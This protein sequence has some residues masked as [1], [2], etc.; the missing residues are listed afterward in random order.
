MLGSETYRRQSEW[1]LKGHYLRVLAKITLPM[2][3]GVLA[4]LLLD[5]ID[6]LLVSQIGTVVMTA[7]GLS[8]PLT[9]L[10]FGVIVGFSIGLVCIL[11]KLISS[12]QCE[13]VK[14][15]IL[16]VLVASLC[17]GVA[18]T[19]FGLVTVDT[20]LDLLGMKFHASELGEWGG[21]RSQAQEYMQLRYIGFCSWMLA[22]MC[23]GVFRALGHTRTAAIIFCVWSL[24]TIVLDSILVGESL[25]L[26]G[27]AWGH[28][29]SDS[30]VSVVTLAYIFNREGLSCRAIYGR[31]LAF[32]RLFRTLAVMSLPAIAYNTMIAAS[33]AWV[34]VLVSNKGTEAVATFTI[35]NRLEPLL[36]LLPM[37]LTMS[38]P[39]FVGHNWSAG[40]YQRTQSGLRACLK[41]IVIFQF[42]VYMF[43]IGAYG[44][45]QYGVNDE[46]PKDALL[47]VF[48]FIVPL[49]YGALG[50]SMMV[51][52][53][54]NALGYCRL[55]LAVSFD[56]IVLCYLPCVTVGYLF[57]GL[58][59][60]FI[61]MSVGNVLAGLLAYRTLFTVIQRSNQE[62]PYRLSIAGGEF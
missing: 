48:I 28:L 49:S 17:I 11:T 19:V 45:W 59:G 15:Q 35:I 55:A 47:I 39:V 8:I 5:F 40:L 7:L 32:I 23:V 21:I 38:L 37:A 31:P 53:S 60:V 4:L 44:V 13:D 10:L 14:R 42:I 61:G 16:G 34:T 58:L 57:W 6:S 43:L 26:L 2:L 25:G 62:Q 51:T 9:N 41:F 27:L 33:L 3:P 36:L 24:L 29:I 56:R 1:L 20:A 18:L 30:L 52:S 22:F 54:L 50:V 46:R 12:A